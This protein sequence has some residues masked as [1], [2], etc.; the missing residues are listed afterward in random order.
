MLFSMR[1]GGTNM[2]PEWIT[3]VEKL[4]VPFSM[5]FAMAIVGYK[6]IAWFGQQVVVPLKDR[7]IDFI[8]ELKILVSKIV[9]SQVTLDSK[10][11]RIFDKIESQAKREHHG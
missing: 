1:A 4:G 2:S 9:D 7:H 6:A 10:V 5:M 11:T 8:D 3:L